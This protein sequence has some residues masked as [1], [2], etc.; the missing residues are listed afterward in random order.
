MRAVLGKERHPIRGQVVQSM[1]ISI[2]GHEI[3]AVIVATS[4]GGLQT[5]VRRSI[6]IREVVNQCEVRGLAVER[7][8]ESG[9]FCAA[10]CCARGNRGGRPP[11][12][13][14]R[15]VEINNPREVYPLVGHRRENEAKLSSKRK[16][17]AHSPVLYIKEAE[18]A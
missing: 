4:Q 11:G 2:A 8:G 6:E 17:E 16:V 10:V 1:R 7:V 5:V 3:E 15:L 9:C 18:S 12:A 13:N 14:G